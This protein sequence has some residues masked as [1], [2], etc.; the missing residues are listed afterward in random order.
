MSVQLALW[1]DPTPPARVRRPAA[2]EPSLFILAEVAHLIDLDLDDGI[3]APE[4]GF[5]RRAVTTCVEHGWLT[6]SYVGDSDTEQGPRRLHITPEGRE[7]L[8]LDDTW[9]AVDR[10]CSVREHVATRLGGAAA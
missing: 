1:G 8:A 4:V 6:R 3:G 2:S 9:C 5:K 7:Q 10:F